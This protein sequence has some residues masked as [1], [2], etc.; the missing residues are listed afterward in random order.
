[1]HT[2]NVRGKTASARVLR[3][4]DYYRQHVG[5]GWISSRELC[6]HA[7]VLNPGTEAAAVRKQIPAPDIPLSIE[8]TQRGMRHFYRVV[9]VAGDGQLNLFG[10]VA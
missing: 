1:M 7:G 8:H 5:N 3:V 2:G 6:R 9:E 4:L 10:G